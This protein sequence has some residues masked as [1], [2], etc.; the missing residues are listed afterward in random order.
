VSA[1]KELATLL[2]ISAV[3]LSEAA[4]CNVERKISKPGISYQGDVK[5]SLSTFTPPA[6]LN[7]QM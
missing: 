6:P 7:L 3:F 1:L 2:L 4:S 5:K